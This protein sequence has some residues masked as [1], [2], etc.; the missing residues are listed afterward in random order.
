[1][2]EILDDIVN[3][4]GSLDQIDML[5]ELADTITNTALCGLG[6]T[7]ASPVV[8]T[9][10]EF[11]DEYISH[12]VDKHCP[13]G[14]CHGLKRIE[15]I[16]DQCKGCAKCQTVCPVNAIVGQRKEPYHIELAKCIKCK[17]C[18]DACPFKAIVEN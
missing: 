16:E 18:I 9:I 1:M 11:K 2:N 6:K 15:I 13:T 12:A 17:R 14:S 10:R 5:L 7:A 4:R 3:G 8:S